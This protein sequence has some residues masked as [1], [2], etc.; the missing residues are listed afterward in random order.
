MKGEVED[1]RKGMEPNMYA[2]PVQLIKVNPADP[3]G[4]Q[5]GFWL[6]N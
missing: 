6:I 5:F 2:G 4:I 3:A 1:R